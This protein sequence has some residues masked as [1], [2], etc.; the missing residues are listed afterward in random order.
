[1]KLDRLYQFF[2]GTM[3]ISPHLFFQGWKSPCTLI[4]C[5]NAFSLSFEFHKV[6]IFIYIAYKVLCILLIL[7]LPLFVGLSPAVSVSCT[8]VAII[9]SHHVVKWQRSK[10]STFVQ[11]CPPSC[12]FWHNTKFREK[13]YFTTALNVSRPTSQIIRIRYM[14]WSATYM[15]KMVNH[16][17]TR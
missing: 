15:R 8:W 4:S 11:L 14:S 7:V 9:I 12:A 5:E 10:L 2:L 17:Y 6:L 16:A 13:L 3:C 1:L